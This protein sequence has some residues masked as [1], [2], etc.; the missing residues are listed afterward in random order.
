MLNMDTIAITNTLSTLYSTPPTFWFEDQ[1]HIYYTQDSKA[2][3]VTLRVAKESTFVFW[4][5]PEDGPD[6]WHRDFQL[7]RVAI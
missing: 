2:C 1:S 5:T 7:N 6:T 4:N 3:E